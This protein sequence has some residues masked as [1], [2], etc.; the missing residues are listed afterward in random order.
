MRAYLITSG[1]LFFLILIAHGMRVAVEGT[2]LVAEPSF[3][4]TSALAAGMCAWAVVLVIRK[5]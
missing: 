5:I 2:R 3:L 1:I 4:A